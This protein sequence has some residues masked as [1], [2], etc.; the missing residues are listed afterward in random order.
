MLQ[1]EFEAR[2]KM[3][4]SYK[5]F[6]SINEVYNNSNLDKDEFCKLWVKMNVS[7]VRKAAE[8]RKEKERVSAIREKAWDII[9]RYNF[10][11]M[12]GKPASSVLSKS[13]MSFCESVG[14]TIRDIDYNPYLSTTIDT[15]V[16]NLRKFL[17]AA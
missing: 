13:Q 7:R 6:E 11:R 15:V 16:C 9:N 17:E 5:E 10:S 1:Q 2:V 14:I 4:V 8:E 3:T 12:Y